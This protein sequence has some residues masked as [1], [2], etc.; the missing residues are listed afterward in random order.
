MTP[1][2]AQPRIFIGSSTEGLPVA[3]ALQENL[4][5][6]AEV[7]VWNQG[8]FAPSSLTL[9]RLMSSLSE[10]DFAIF[11][12]TADDLLEMRGQKFSAVRDNV[13]FELG[14]FI[15]KLGLSRCFF[16]LP[17]H[18]ENFRLPTDLLG[19]TPL[20]YNSN[21]SDG[22]LVAAVGAASNKIRAAMRSAE[23]EEKLRPTSGAGHDG[24]FSQATLNDYLQLWEAPEMSAARAKVRNIDSDPR[25]DE[26]QAAVPAITKIYA[27]LESLSDRI[28]A[29]TLDETKVR[30]IFGDAVRSFWPFYA[31]SSFLRARPMRTM[32]GRSYQSSEFCIPGGRT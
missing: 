11:V 21:R 26:F 16:I 10:Y 6:E 23:A 13:I 5:Y 12:F 1:I 3:Y 14:L 24:I 32:P 22:L 20:T 18:A 15:G 31:I 27:F 4:D 28:L 8:I 17:R 7:T 2:A 9:S 29:G 19:V 30:A 25:S